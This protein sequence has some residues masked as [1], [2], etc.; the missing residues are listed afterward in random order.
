M[1]AAETDSHDRPLAHLVRREPIVA[2]PDEPLRA[3]VYRMAETGVTR[4]PVVDRGDPPTLVG[5]LGLRDL[6]RA[7]VRSLEEEHRRERVLRIH[8]LVPSG[9]SRN[10]KTWSRARQLVHH[11]PKHA[12]PA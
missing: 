4:M 7:R 11:E 10:G 6:L 2:Y 1:E 9:L 3:V 8:R 12:P 5:I